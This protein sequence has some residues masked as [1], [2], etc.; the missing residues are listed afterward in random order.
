MRDRGWPEGHC[1]SVWGR[2]YLEHL[3]SLSDGDDIDPFGPAVAELATDLLGVPVMPGQGP[4]QSLVQLGGHAG[5]DAARAL[6]LAQ[7]I[8]EACE[9]VVEG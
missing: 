4:G 6:A 3:R 9:G 1:E 7:Q 5:G 8:V 2:S